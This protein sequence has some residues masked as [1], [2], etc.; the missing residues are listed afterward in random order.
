MEVNDD[1]NA[2]TALPSRNNS[3]SQRSSEWVGSRPGLEVFGNEEISE[4][5]P[6]SGLPY[7]YSSPNP[8]NPQLE[9]NILPLKTFQ[10]TKFFHGKAK[11]YP[12]R[13]SENLLA[14]YCGRHIFYKK[15]DLFVIKWDKN[16]R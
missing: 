16:L 6:K 14:V 10:M 12:R 15:K 11:I 3:V 13:D 5:N 8:P 7:P 4:M 9:G 1:L 2:P